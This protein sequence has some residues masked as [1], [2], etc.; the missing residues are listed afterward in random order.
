[1][2]GNLCPLNDGTESLMGSSSSD[3]FQRFSFRPQLLGLENLASTALDRFTPLD[4]SDVGRSIVSHT[5]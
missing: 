4:T 1:V 5:I 2:A 3:S